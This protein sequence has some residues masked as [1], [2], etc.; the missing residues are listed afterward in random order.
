M[1]RRAG[2]GNA[3]KISPQRSGMPGAPRIMRQSA[4]KSPSVLVAR[5]KPFQTGKKRGR[6]FL[7]RCVRGSKKSSAM[8]GFQISANCPAS[9]LA[10]FMFG[11]EAR[12][13]FAILCCAG[14]AARPIACHPARRNSARAAMRSLSSQPSSASS[15]RPY[16][17]PSPSGAMRSL[18]RRT[19]PRITAASSAQFRLSTSTGSPI[20][21]P[22][23]RPSIA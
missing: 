9:R 16:R 13:R 18:M 4:S 23:S 20:Y 14:R 5:L 15:A 22:K 19:K 3:P 8:A 2:R 21:G 6:R 1:A 7:P 10:S 12:G 11:A 17:K